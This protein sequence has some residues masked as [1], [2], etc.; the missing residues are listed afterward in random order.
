[1]ARDGRVS[2]AT[3]EICELL[4]TMVQQQT[5]IMQQ[6]AALLQVHSE[7]VR[8]QGLL[9]EHLLR[10]PASTGEPAPERQN[11]ARSSLVAHSNM[12]ATGAAEREAASPRSEDAPPTAAETEPPE[13]TEP[14]ETAGIGRPLEANDSA[15]V[16]TAQ[17]AHRAARY[18]QP[19][20]RTA[21]LPLRPHDLAVMRKLHELGDVGA[22]I[23]QFGPYKGSTLAQIAM[24][25][26]DYLRQLAARAQRPEVRAAAA[27]VADAMQEVGDV[28]RGGNRRTARPGQPAA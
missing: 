12:L 16:G 13:S 10:V 27:R 9:L 14:E 1:M 23:L 8:M 3:P 4:Q 6:Q 26:P 18:Y 25:Q 2:A 19:S 28:K 15:A 7:T 24:R 21:S 22:L 5:A 17:V 11:D 20:V